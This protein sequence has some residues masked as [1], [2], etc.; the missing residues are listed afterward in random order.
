MHRQQDPHI[1]SLSAFKLVRCGALQ[2]S[3][4]RAPALLECVAAMAASPSLAPVL[5]GHPSLTQASH[6][7][8][9]VE[10][11]TVAPVSLPLGHK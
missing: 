10:G 4:V 1:H 8:P 3:S 7:S 6:T 9:A 5:A 2:A 11:S